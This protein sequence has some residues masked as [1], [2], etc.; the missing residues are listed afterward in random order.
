MNDM[1]RM[2]SDSV[3]LGYDSLEHGKNDS[4]SN[5]FFSKHKKYQTQGNFVQAR[6]DP[7]IEANWLELSVNSKVID[8][9]RNS[10]K[11]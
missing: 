7:S 11:N 1:D 4:L 5:K 6:Y 9:L 8:P 10:K 3:D 2:Y